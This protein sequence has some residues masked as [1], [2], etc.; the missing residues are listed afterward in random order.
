[1]DYK[2]IV[3]QDAH[4]DIDEIIGYIVNVLKN[5][6]AAGKL[7][8][9]IEKSYKTIIQNPETFAFCNDNRLRE[10]GYR[11][12]IVKN[13]IVFYRVDYETNTVN[14]MRVIY[15]RRDYTNLI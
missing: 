2:L 1:M 13:Y 3:T 10:E 12:I 8:A 14:V 4:E 9:E 7:L 5:P 15:G 6:I 11:K